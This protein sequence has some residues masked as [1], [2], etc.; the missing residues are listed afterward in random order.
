MFKTEF[1]EENII[2]G[3]DAITTYAKA[4]GIVL[5]DVTKPE[6]VEKVLKNTVSETGMPYVRLSATAA[7]RKVRLSTVLW[8][9]RRKQR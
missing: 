7:L 8:R 1:K 9:S 6:Y 5:S 2:K 3:K 4:K